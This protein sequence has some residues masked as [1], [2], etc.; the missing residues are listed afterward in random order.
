MGKAS[1]SKRE[2]HEAEGGSGGSLPKIDVPSERRSLPVFWIVVALIVVGGIV[3]IVL[4]APDD[5]TKERE[6]AAS[7]A[8]LYADV[9]VS[10]DNLTS[11]D[12]QGTDPGVGETAPTISGTN[13]DN[14]QTTIQPGNGTARVYVVM[15]HWCPHCQAEIPRI[16]EWTSENPLPEGVEITGISTS[17]DKGNPNFPP[18]EW[19]AR[20]D[21]QFETLADDELGTA[22]EA[23]GVEGFPYLVFTN[24]DGEVV[25]RFSGEMPIE[26]FADAIDEI[27]PA[28]AGATAAATQE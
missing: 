9:E 13:F 7:D 20:E 24:A 4:T 3:A 5:A 18:A 22:S 15:A 12:G 25:S 21:W 2:R 27:T 14:E 1:R 19:L 11:W 16:V 26:D 10:G 8:P 23:L 28:A 17:V 6:A